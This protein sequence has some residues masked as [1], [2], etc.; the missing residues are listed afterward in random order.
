MRRLHAALSGRL[1]LPSAPP[2]CP[3]RTPLGQDAE[4]GRSRSRAWR[5][6]TSG[7]ACEPQHCPAVSGLLVSEACRLQPQSLPSASASGAAWLCWVY[8]QT[9]TCPFLSQLI[10]CRRPFPARA[11]GRPAVPS[12]TCWGPRVLASRLSWEDR[13][14]HDAG[15]RSGGR[16]SYEG[17]H[18]GP[19]VK[20]R[21]LQ[22]AGRRQLCR[23]LTLWAQCQ[24]H[25]S[26]AMG[27]RTALQPLGTEQAGRG[28]T[29][30]LVRGGGRESPGPRTAGLQVSAS[31]GRR[32]GLGKDRRDHPFAQ[33]R[34]D[35]KRA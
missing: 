8:F 14:G 4:S 10:S 5:A 33:C 26:P 6:S 24:R 35:G 7:E 27:T 12:G 18:S 17:G 21:A 22:D 11:D 1:N 25:P 3:S 30:A 2:Q 34:G 9:P 28:E 29:G 19:A 15:R 16:V 23:D 32:T 20:T 31:R 13:T